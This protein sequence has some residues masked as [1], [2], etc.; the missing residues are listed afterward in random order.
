M[1]SIL[2]LSALAALTACGGGDATKSTSV[3]NMS[4][5]APVAAKAAPAGTNWV[6]TVTR[7]PEGGWL[8]GNPD[9][10]IKLVEFGSRT[11]HV[12]REFDEKGYT[13]LTTQY[14]ATG[15]VSWEFRDFLRNGAD[16]AAALVGGCGGTGP[17]FPLLNQMYADQPRVLDTLQKLPQ[18]YYDQLANMTLAQQA[19]KFAEAAGYIDF[20]KQR[21]IPDAK[22]RQCLADTGETEK[23]QKMNEK[24]NQD[25]TIPGTPT[26]LLNGKMLENTVAWEQVER[27]LKAAGA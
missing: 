25:Y 18:G 27:A 14:I 17:F 6:E 7:T 24:A 26:F 19:T 22:V 3:E 16:V 5:A 9:A 10:P 2:A 13:P 8:M 15:K 12:C 20:A 1:R 23:L 11:C 4:Q 21:G